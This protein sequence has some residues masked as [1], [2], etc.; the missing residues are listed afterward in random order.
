MAKYNF[1]VSGIYVLILAVSTHAFIDINKDI[2]LE[3]KETNQKH[4]R[5]GWH[6]IRNVVTES[7]DDVIVDIVSYQQ[8]FLRNPPKTIEDGVIDDFYDSFNFLQDVSTEASL[9][10]P[11]QNMTDSTS[12]PTYI[13]QIPHATVSGEYL[14]YHFIYQ[15]SFKRGTNA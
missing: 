2:V 9:Y 6:I 14:L 5:F 15:I 4:N 8:P 3:T 13:A 11:C 1:I 12:C 7:P 10:Y